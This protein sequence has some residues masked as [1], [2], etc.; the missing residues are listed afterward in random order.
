MQKSLLQEIQHAVSKKRYEIAISSRDEYIRTIITEEADKK[1]GLDLDLDLGLGS[2]MEILK[3]ICDKS[4]FT[5]QIS[6]KM[7]AWLLNNKEYWI[8]EDALRIMQK[9]YRSMKNNEFDTVIESCETKLFDTDNKVREAA[10]GL[11][12][13]ILQSSLK[14]YPD[15]YLTYCQMFEDESWRV[16]ARALGGVLDFLTPESEPSVELIGA[17]TEKIAPLLRD[18]DEEIR[19]LS[20]EVLKKLFFHMDAPSITALLLPILNDVD[21]E[22]R[23]KGI[24]IA[25]EIGTLYFDDFFEIFRRLIEMFS[26]TIMM[27]QT[28]TIDAFV[29]I[30]QK[31]GKEL[32]NF[33]RPFIISSQSD[34]KLIDQIEGISESLIIITIQQIK[35]Y[36]PFLIHELADSHLSVRKIIGNCLKKVYIE[37]SDAF[38]EE[39]FLMFQ[40]LNPDDWRQRKQT[41]GLLGDLSYLLH[42][43][44][45]AVWTAINLKN[46]VEIEQDLDVLDEIEASLTKIRNV[47]AQI[48]V[49]IQEIEER[50]NN[51]YD[52]LKM[53]HGKIR[54]LRLDT[55][56][57]IQQK[58]F[59][60][61]EMYLEEQGSQI[62]EKLDEYEFLLL[63]SEFKRFSVEIV[64]DF[65]ESKEEILENI[66]DVK[67][68]LFMK[69]CDGRA[70]YLETLHELIDHLRS[71]IDV[72]QAEHESI[73]EIERD[74]IEMIDQNEM[75]K[76]QST[77][78]CQST[79]PQLFVR[80]WAPGL[81]HSGRD[82]RR[83]TRWYA[84]A[85][86][87]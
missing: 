79:Y 82:Q 19:G 80:S 56:K 69:I 25:G 6:L 14:R 57:L 49:K 20:S 18:T 78:Q 4:D 45:I 28:K 12:S 33:F 17:F 9:L 84:V 24:W 46:M 81:N 39:I 37:R 44:S 23:S 34:Q 41:I 1:S 8:R 64:Q 70:N 50:K 16:R 22:I 10:V 86:Q 13:I 52:G 76:D 55:E 66:S 68:S 27:V 32:I 71:R 72:V 35:D 40:T 7:A 31:K 74:L 75:A 30:G 11:I 67:N 65:K 87:I 26:D 63:Q 47:F 73:K 36:L 77:L 43:E 5:I 48:D 62:S 38:E 83:K 53:F 85:K 3:A 29:K 42:T 61:A 59:Y 15:L 60:D 51:F 2:C 21:W 58:K 54:N